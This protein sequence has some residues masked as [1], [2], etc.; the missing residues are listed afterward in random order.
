MFIDLYSFGKEGGETFPVLEVEAKAL[1]ESLKEAV[2]HSFNSFQTEGYNLGVYF[3]SY[4]NGVMSASHP[5]A[6]VQGSGISDLSRFVKE[7]DGWVP[8]KEVKDSLLDLLFY[9]TF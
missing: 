8:H 5:D 9:T 4:E 7:S 3:A 6:Y 2:P 1:Q